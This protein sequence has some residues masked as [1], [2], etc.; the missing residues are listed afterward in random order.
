[1]YETLS[2]RYVLFSISMVL[3]NLFV[4]IL[5]VFPS[6]ARR[7]SYIHNVVGNSGARISYQ[8]QNTVESD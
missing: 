2:E 8:G 1:M 5:L 7:I 4:S 6:Y 3:L